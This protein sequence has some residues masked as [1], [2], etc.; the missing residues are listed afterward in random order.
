MPQPS[1]QLYSG[2]T[3]PAM[4]RLLEYLLTP[5]PL[6]HLLIDLP[7]S[8]HSQARQAK[9]VEDLDVCLSLFTDSARPLDDFH[10]DLLFADDLAQDLGIYNP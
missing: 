7:S 3:A 4:R 1:T 6:E 2:D 8:I 5:T 10:P 9:L